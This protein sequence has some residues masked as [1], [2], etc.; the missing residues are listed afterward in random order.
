M[1]TITKQGI[2]FS[3]DGWYFINNTTLIEGYF[4]I[5][6]SGL[7]FHVSSFGSFSIN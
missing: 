5:Q 7:T 6:K 4:R 2:D 1:N 3:K